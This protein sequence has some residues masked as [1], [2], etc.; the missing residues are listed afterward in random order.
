[1]ARAVTTARGGAGAVREI[2]AWLL[3]PELHTTAPPPSS[4]TPPRSPQGK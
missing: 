4:G 1:A 3:G 2:A